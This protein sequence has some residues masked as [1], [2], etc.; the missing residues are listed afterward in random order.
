MQ[1]SIA[2][3]DAFFPAMTLSKKK[4]HDEERQKPTLSPNP[5]TTRRFKLT[6]EAITLL[7]AIGSAKNSR[8]IADISDAH[9]FKRST[10]AA[11]LAKMVDHGLIT[12]EKTHQPFP[13]SRS[14]N[15]R[16]TALAAELLLSL[17]TSKD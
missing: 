11:N 17:S 4:L 2:S 8:E 5:I 6:L 13:F 16:S 10:T 1:T 3:I 7:K 15:Y 12:L 9:G 14:T